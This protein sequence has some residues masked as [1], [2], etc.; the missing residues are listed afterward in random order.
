MLFSLAIFSLASFLAIFATSFWQLLILR[1]LMGIF[2]P[3]Y[4]ALALAIAA[5]SAL[6]PKDA[7]K[8]VAKVFTGVSAGMVLGVPMGS[9]LGW[10]FSY[11]ASQAFFCMLTSLCLILTFFFIKDTGKGEKPH[12][13]EQVSIL[14]SPLLWLSIVAVIIIQAAIFGF[15]GYLSDF[16]HKITQLNFTYISIILATYGGANIIGNILAG[17][18][19]STNPN[20]SLALS[21]IAIFLLYIGIFVGAENALILTLLILILGVLAGLMNNG[22]H[23]L[24]TQ[25]F[26]KQAE[27]TNGIFLSV[28]NI[29]L[30]LGTIICGYVA[31]MIDLK[32]I[33]LSACVLLVLG[34]VTVA[35]RSKIKI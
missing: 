6:N 3:I 12:L 33:A 2:H 8:E 23:F 20:K 1:A 31:D 27:F 30:S 4:T 35:L 34:F 10:T 18:A 28:A 16:L 7:P 26:P 14:K 19:L 24:I 17:K 9:F 32:M 21:M 13:Q 25:P 5:K 29:G 11:Q 22:V 15:Y